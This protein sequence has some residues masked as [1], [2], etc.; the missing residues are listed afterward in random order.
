MVETTIKSK[1]KKHPLA[2]YIE[3]L[4]SGDALLPDTPD[5]LIEVVGVLHS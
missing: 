2:E 3:R 5:N 4:L 1:S